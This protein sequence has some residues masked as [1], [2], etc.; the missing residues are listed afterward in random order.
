MSKRSIHGNHKINDKGRKYFEQSFD[1]EHWIVRSE[2]SEQKDYF[3]DYTLEL[4]END[5][6]TGE[7]IRVQLKSRKSLKVKNGIVSQR[8]KTHHFRYWAEQCDRPVFLVVVDTSRENGYAVFIQEWA[9]RN[10]QNLNT[11]WKD[12]TTIEIKFDNQYII[13]NAGPVKQYAYGAIRYM[14]EKFPGSIEAAVRHQREKIEALDPRFSADIQYI[15]Q[16]KVIG[17]N[18]KE[19]VN[20]KLTVKGKID[21]MKLSDTLAFGKESHLDANNV[22]FEGSDLIKEMMQGKDGVISFEPS[23]PIAA[24]FRFFDSNSKEFLF[25]IP[26]QATGGLHGCTIT[27]TQPE[28]PFK[29]DTIVSREGSMIPN[30]TVGLRGWKGKLI[31]EIGYFEDLV[32]II[33]LVDKGHESHIDIYIKGSYGGRL[34]ASVDILRKLMEAYGLWGEV[35]T[36]ARG[37]DRILTINMTFDDVCRGVSTEN[38]REIL[39]IYSFFEKRNYNVGDTV[40][41]FTVSQ[42]SNLTNSILKEGKSDGTFGIEYG[43]V[44]IDVFGVKAKVWKLRYEFACCEIDFDPSEKIEFLAGLR[45]KLEVRLRYLEKSDIDKMYDSIEILERSSLG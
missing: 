40:A 25:V 15:G 42:Q 44:E 36:A 4:V 5:N 21:A 2:G 7:A 1:L 22:F 31:S 37:L 12:K 28:H 9:D 18:A 6:P 27:T 29:V 38:Y 32:R 34:H 11:D 3:I 14:R 24:E 16:R 10:L 26:G 35:F 8:V 43:Y 23:K 39:E 19:E 17:L 20:L 13:S 30:V 33:S 45:D 41:Q